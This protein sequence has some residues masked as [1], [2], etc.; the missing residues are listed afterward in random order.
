MDGIDTSVGAASL[1]QV[2]STTT[3]TAPVKLAAETAPAQTSVGTANA[4]LISL[5][6]D[7]SPPIDSK[8]VEAIRSLIAQGRYP[9]D[10]RAIAAKM[11]A[12]DAPSPK[13]V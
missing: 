6:A 8:K 10:S 2:R 13:D 4:N 12:L 7:A 1:A 11:I 3:T 5:L 9:I